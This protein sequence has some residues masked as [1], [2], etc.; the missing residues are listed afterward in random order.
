MP[1]PRL[2]EHRWTLVPLVIYAITRVIDGILLHIGASR[3]A[4][5][6][7]T[8]PGYK[9]TTPTPE[10]P[11]YLGV[12]S[13]WDGQW[14]RTIAENGYPTTLPEVGG[15]VVPNEWAFSGG[16]PFLVRLLMMIARI[17]FPLAATV[18]SLACGAVAMVVLYGMVREWMDD[19]AA[20]TLVLALCCFPSAPVLQVA[21]TESMSLLLVV[22][23]L[24]AL[25][26]QRHG[27]FLVWAALLSVTRPLLLPLGLLAAA[28]WVVRWRRRD[29]VEFPRR[30]RVVSAVACVACVAMAAVWPAIAAVVTR[31]TSAFTET[32]AAWPTNKSLGGATVNWLTL[33]AANPAIVG[34]FV[35]PVLALV[36]YAALRPTAKTLPATVRWWAP[37]Y[38]VYMFAATKPSAGILRYILL[39]IFPL[40][41]LL[42]PRTT[43]GSR[44]DSLMQWLVPVALAVAGIVGQYYWVM[45]IFTIDEA[46]SVQPFP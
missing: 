11:G 17:E 40:S 7:S 32:M 26:T 22:L 41:P 9:L 35:L 20:T 44:A 23:A 42:E 46:P 37:I 5:I 2:T 16:Y 3:Q 33:A 4:A 39:A 10:S 18:V 24:H 34:A 29:V 27:W 30:E 31:N 21:Y 19:Y 43:S 14:F 1:R 15:E 28:T 6:T 38:M 45:K 8:T 25:S 36:A 13:N 12:V